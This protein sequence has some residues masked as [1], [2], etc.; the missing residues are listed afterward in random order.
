M[1]NYVCLRPNDQLMDFS[2]VIGLTGLV[3]S[4]LRWLLHICQQ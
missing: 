4:V 1:M 3:D 2:P